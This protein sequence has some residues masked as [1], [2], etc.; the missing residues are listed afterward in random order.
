MQICDENDRDVSMKGH[1][2]SWICFDFG[3]SGVQENSFGANRFGTFNR[4]L[5][6]AD[7]YL[8]FPFD[9]DPTFLLS[10]ALPFFYKSCG[11][12]PINK[13]KIS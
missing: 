3:G 5:F 13:L 10:Y 12:C 4:P 8:T 7:P 9:A 11:M 2:A 6:Y 1:C